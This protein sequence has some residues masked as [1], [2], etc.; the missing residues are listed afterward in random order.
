MRRWMVAA[1]SGAA[2]TMAALPAYAQGAWKSYTVKELGFSF[3]APGEVKAEVGTFRGAIAG[4]RQTM[5]FRS[6]ANNI[7][8]KVTVMTFLQAQAEGATILG[9]R[10]YMF[11][12]NRNT[13]VDT[14]ARVEPGKD[15]VYGRKMVVELPDNKGRSTGAFFFTKGKLVAMEATVLPANGDYQSPDPARFVEFD[16]FQCHAGRNRRHRSAAAEARLDRSGLEHTGLFLRDSPVLRYGDRIMPRLGELLYWMAC[17][18]AAIVAIL[19]ITAVV[20]GDR[21]SRI[22]VIA[23]FIASAVIWLIG[24]AALF[25]SRNK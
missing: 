16:R 20:Q 6:L 5:V 12:E 2:L 24:R 14:F 7:E 13:L 3:M 8:Y 15:S 1:L 11:Q 22:G 21:Q 17:W 9:E 25:M 19:G 10:T 4:P 23:F 18:I